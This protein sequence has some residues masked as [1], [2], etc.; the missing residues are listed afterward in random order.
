MLKDSHSIIVKQ[1]KEGQS[2]LD[3]GCGDGSLL[4]RLQK[5]KNCKGYGIEINADLVQ[6]CLKKGLNVYQ[7]D[8][9]ESLACFKDNHFD[10]VLLSQTLQQTQQPLDIMN[11]MCRAA[12]IA[13]V[14]FPNFAYWKC[15][16]DLLR[17]Y[18][19]R[20]K[21]LPFEWHDTPNTRVVSIKSFRK[22][23][24]DQRFDILKEE[25][26]FANSWKKLLP[27][28]SNLLAEKALF[29]IKKGP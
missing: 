8:I 17:G 11:E 15:R 12:D 20:S 9:L 21:T 26:M 10:V 18:I 19:P 22:V 25:A 27:L 13:I 5:E 4:E 6:S 2:V 14:T 23:C 16:L 29:I 24:A 28:P 3:L 1:I 7:G